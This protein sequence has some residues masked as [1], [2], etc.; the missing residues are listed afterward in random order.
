MT[1]TTLKDL[2]GSVCVDH[3]NERFIPALGNGSSVPGD[4]VY[5]DPANGRVA[6]ADKTTA[7]F[8]QGI[9]MESKIT[10]PETA[11]VADIPCTVVVPKS[12]HEYNIRITIVAAA[13]DKAGSGVIF[14]DDAGKGETTMAGSTLALSK[15]GRLVLDAL[16]GDTVARI[17]WIE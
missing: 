2:G 6:G 8:F 11:I 14:H 3:Q 5:I 12:G 15:I 4:L 16:V 7:A 1:K 10:G 9:L 13:T 17:T